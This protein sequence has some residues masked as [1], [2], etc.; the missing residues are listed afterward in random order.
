MEM[1]DLKGLLMKA[2]EASHQGQEEDV[3]YF[4]LHL[5]KLPIHVYLF[6]HEY[7]CK[8]LIRPL[9]LSPLLE[10]F[11]NL[12][13]LHLPITSICICSKFWS[14]FLP[15]R[16]ILSSPCLNVFCKEI[17]EVAMWCIVSVKWNLFYCNILLYGPRTQPSTFAKTS[18]PNVHATFVW[19]VFYPVSRPTSQAL[20]WFLLVFASSRPWIWLWRKQSYESSLIA[21]GHSTYLCLYW[22]LSS[23]WYLYSTLCT[24]EHYR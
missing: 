23:T 12:R 17:F 4:V 24:W 11:G 15:L 9:I 14:N 5:N 20:S 21:T 18:S 2:C 22:A 13:L 7:T 3:Q 16:L 6:H 19:I 10:I 8:I 1:A